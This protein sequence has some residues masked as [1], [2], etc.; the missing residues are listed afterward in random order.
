MFLLNPHGSHVKISSRQS[1]KNFNSSYFVR[2]G[3]DPSGDHAFDGSARN[4]EE[5][6][7]SNAGQSG[8]FRDST[9]GH[10]SRGNNEMNDVASI[11]ECDMGVN[12]Y[13]SKLSIPLMSNV[14]MTEFVPMMCAFMKERVEEMKEWLNEDDSDETDGSDVE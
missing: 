4:D 8:T 9:E 13:V 12:D 10:A 7:E 2:T 3:T 5:S 14:V 1:C 11:D 6:P